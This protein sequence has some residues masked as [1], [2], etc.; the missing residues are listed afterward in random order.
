MFSVR[1]IL[2]VSIAVGKVSASLR[3]EKLS[4]QNLSDLASTSPDSVELYPSPSSSGSPKQMT[5]ETP[6]VPSPETKRLTTESFNLRSRNG[7]EKPSLQEKR[8]A[9]KIEVIDD[10]NRTIL[11]KRL[12][13]NEME[14]LVDDL[15]REKSAA[16]SVENGR[17]IDSALPPAQKRKRLPSE[18]SSAVEEVNVQGEPSTESKGKAARIYRFKF[19]SI[20]ED[21]L[22]NRRKEVKQMTEEDQKLETLANLQ[23]LLDK[24]AGKWGLHVNFS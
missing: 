13:A 16:A 8:H 4:V 20:H 19:N 2:A 9:D 22:R 1:N 12:E 11:M 17:R 23:A 21:W 5:S 3:R 18:L 7:R 6:N 24:K 10:L 14:S 15:I